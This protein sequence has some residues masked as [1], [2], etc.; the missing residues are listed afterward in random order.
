[1]QITGTQKEFE[2]KNLSEYLDL[3][4]Q[5]NT[6][7]VADVFNKFRNIYR[8]IFELDPGHFLFGKCTAGFT[9]ISMAS[10]L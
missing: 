7:L 2:I 3:H 1:M 10:N 9:R 4:V 8:E 6:L 5:S